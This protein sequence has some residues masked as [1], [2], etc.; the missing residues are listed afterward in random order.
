[1][2]SNMKKEKYMGFELSG[3]FRL[4]LLTKYIV[5]GSPETHFMHMSVKNIPFDVNIDHFL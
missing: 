2:F 1:M 5:L 3:I 4:K